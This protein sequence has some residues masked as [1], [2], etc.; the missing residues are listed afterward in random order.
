MN[1]LSRR[2]L[3]LSACGA[4]GLAA[5]R[6]IRI[7]F[8]GVGG[9]GTDLLHNILEN[10]DIDVPVL[11]DLNEKSLT[12]AADLVQKARG[13][14]PETFSRGPLDYKR[15]LARDD[16]RAVLI[17]TPQE[18]HA[19][20]SIDAML[21]GK[22]VGSEV[23]AATTLEECWELVRTQQKTKS[24]YMLLENYRYGRNV[25]QVANMAEK[26]LFGELTYAEC[27][28]IHE[29]RSMRFNP[30]GSLTWR[31]KNVAENIGDLYPTHSVGPV[32]GWMGINRSDRLVSMVTMSSKSAATHEYAARRFGKDSA[33]G[34]V[35]FLNGDTNNTL[36][37]TKLGRLI[38]VRYDVAS[39][40]PAGM[41]QYSL[42]GTR[43]AYSAAFGQNKVY[44]EGRSRPH[45]WDELEKYRPEHEHPYWA[46]R[47]EAASKTG[48]GGG[49]Y[50]VL[51]D[52]I[53][54]I[55][56]GRSPIDVYDAATWSCIRPLSAVSLRNKSAPVEIPHFA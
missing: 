28:Y 3:L 54:A 38:S 23:P 43:G 8:L 9:R 16:F 55:Q 24:G 14:R 39:P 44:I 10:T 29:I 17:A 4:A 35:P 13:S 2:S 21:A 30:D 20:M 34:K 48:H 47:G 37:R 50:F 27:A 1:P 56:T 31:G 36:I 19:R 18:D 11:C 52:F 25:M 41:G 49:D 6:E 12:R 45:E 7:A 33:P 22:F 46:A 40:R 26:G 42:Q 5:G 32:C 51:T 53:R 15:M